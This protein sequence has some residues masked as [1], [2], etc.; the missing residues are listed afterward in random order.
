MLKFF[1][2]DLDGTLLDSY[3]SIVSSL[4]EVAREC[5]AGDS[6][7]GILKTVKDTAVSVYL[8]DLAERSGRDYGK[9][10]QRYREISHERLEEITLIPG[11]VRTLERL[12]NGGARHFVYTHRGGSTGSL[13]ERLGLTGYFEEIV[14]FEYGLKPKPS[15]EGVEYLVRRYGLAREETAYV[16]DRHLDVFCAKDAGV[17]AVL[18]CPEDSCVSPAGQEDLVISRLEELADLPEG[19]RPGQ[20]TGGG[21]SNR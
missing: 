5:G 11:A 18:Y 17:K 14:T 12:K 20:R 9:L 15:G 4:T 13:L 3:G 8:R 16:G 19:L 2:W 6:R 1:I 7:D 10:Y 21:L